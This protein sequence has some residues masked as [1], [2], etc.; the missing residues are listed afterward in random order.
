MEKEQPKQR[1]DNNSRRE[2]GPRPRQRLVLMSDINGKSIPER[3]S[4]CER[5]CRERYEAVHKRGQRLIAQL[6]NFFDHLCVEARVRMDMWWGD[7]RAYRRV[8]PRADNQGVGSE[9]I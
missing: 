2:G 5:R 9:A 1:A 4:E 3:Y 6:L 7:R 8:L